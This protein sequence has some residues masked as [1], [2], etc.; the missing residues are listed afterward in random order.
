M[1]NS[2]GIYVIF[3]GL[4]EI[5]QSLQCMFFHISCTWPRRHTAQGGLWGKGEQVSFGAY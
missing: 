1:Q 4:L 5:A 2:V 3:D